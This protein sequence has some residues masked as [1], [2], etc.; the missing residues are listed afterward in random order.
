MLF[1]VAPMASAALPGKN[2]R[3]LF[4]YQP[5]SS[6]PFE[7]GLRT[8]NPD[9]SSI[10]RASEFS[11][12]KGNARFTPDGRSLI[13]GDWPIGDGV[14][15]RGLFSES[16]TDG[17]RSLIWEIPDL[18][19]YQPISVSPDATKM[20]LTHFDAFCDTREC[21]TMTVDPA[22]GIYLHYLTKKS[23]L[24]IAA[25]KAV[26]PRETIFSPDGRKIAFVSTDEPQGGEGTTIY[27]ANL[28]GT[29]R[30]KVLAG[31]RGVSGLSFSP[32]GRDIAYSSDGQISSVSVKSGKVRQLTSGAIS[33]G[34]AYSPDGTRIA[35]SRAD[36]ASGFIDGDVWTMAR[37]GSNAK[38]LVANVG[39]ESLLDW[40][41]AEPFRIVRYN[42]K[43][44]LV[45]VRTWG[46]GR[47]SVRGPKIAFRSRAIVRSGI[48]RVAVTPRARVRMKAGAK[49]KTFVRFAP[50]GALPSVKKRFVRL[51]R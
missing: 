25:G 16:L 51:G 19:F 1:A 7:A 36:S 34:P 49:V 32:D 40:S 22:N 28:D 33:S 9:G 12:Y 20:I 44:S 24:K 38:P 47:V 10:E 29:S 31:A 15:D 11:S 41:R 48:V 27:T 2:G 46:P 17:S 50:N 21:E 35:F 37:D 5:R 13:Y 18:L 6:V 30:R 14:N 8:I 39:S 43:K 42:R 26:Y 45:V 23:T 3:L 4:D